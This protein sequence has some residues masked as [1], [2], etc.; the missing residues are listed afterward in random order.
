MKQPLPDGGDPTK[1]SKRAKRKRQ[2][3]NAEAMQNASNAS[4]GLK[5]DAFSEV[6]AGVDV[7]GAG[8]DFVPCDPESPTGQGGAKKPHPGP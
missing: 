6:V 7:S 3:A 5:L 1:E 8:A 2:K 4:A